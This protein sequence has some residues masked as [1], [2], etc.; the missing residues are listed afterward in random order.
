MLFVCVFT[1]LW[2]VL[3]SQ[4]WDAQAGKG[5]SFSFSEYST[6]TVSSAWK[7]HLLSQWEEMNV[8]LTTHQLCLPLWLHVWEVFC[9][10]L[11]LM[12]SQCFFVR[13]VVF[14]TAF[15][16]TLYYAHV[17]LFFLMC[18]LLAEQSQISEHKFVSWWERAKCHKWFQH[19]HSNGWL[20]LIHTT[21]FTAEHC[22]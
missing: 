22:S 20:V 4:H 5:Q 19:S 17:V 12:S 15:C 2:N 11:L 13:W 8:L 14:A 6:L 9:C 16:P 3:R 1:V 7:L 21:R 10:T 18:T